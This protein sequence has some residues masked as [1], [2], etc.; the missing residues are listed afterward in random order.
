MLSN[1]VEYSGPVSEVKRGYVRAVDRIGQCFGRLT[2]LRLAGRDARSNA[3]L[4]CICACGT[5]TEVLCCSLVSGD[6]QSCGCLQEEVRV[7]HGMH[8]TPEYNTWKGMIQRCTNDKHP[9]YTRY[10][11]CG[12]SVCPRW[13]KFENFYADM[14]QRPV[15]RSL[16]RIDNNGPYCKENCRWATRKEQ[17]NNRKSNRVLVLGGRSQTLAQWASELGV[18]PVTLY[19]RLNTL[20]WSVEKTLTTPIRIRSGHAE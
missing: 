16:D 15:G 13:L 9:A 18:K 8:R 5:T 3:I 7:K 4:T 2:V 17:C 1:E 6:V 11:G 10:G 12:V 14:G 20:E 19:N